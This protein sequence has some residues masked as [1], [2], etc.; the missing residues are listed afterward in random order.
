MGREM[1]RKD[2]GLVLIE[3]FQN[4]IGEEQLLSNLSEWGTL[5]VHDSR[6]T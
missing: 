3:R 5:R 6:S 2:L 1:A 4:M